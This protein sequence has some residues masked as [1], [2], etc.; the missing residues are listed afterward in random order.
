MEARRLFAERF[1]D[2]LPLL[3]VCLAVAPDVSLDYVS[4]L[5]GECFLKHLDR[6]SLEQVDVDAYVRGASTAAGEA[7]LASAGAQEIEAAV[8]HGKRHI[9]LIR[10]DP[11]GDVHPVLDAL[12]YPALEA[13]DVVSLSA[14][15]AIADTLRPAEPVGRS[16]AQRLATSALGGQVDWMTIWAWIE[17]LCGGSATLV[18]A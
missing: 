14:A 18:Q 3:A 9:A 17:P 5:M 12:Q 15:L 6:I 11:I 13:L 16:H 2:G 7:G 1:H 10:K 8:R 4:D